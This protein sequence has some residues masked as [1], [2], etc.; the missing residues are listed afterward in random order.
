MSARRCKHDPAFKAKVALA[1]LREDATPASVGLGH[2]CDNDEERHVTPPDLTRAR[3]R[4]LVTAAEDAASVALPLETAGP[5]PDTLRSRDVFRLLR[6]V[7]PFVRPYKRHLLYLIIAMLP[8]LVL[9]LAGLILIQIFFDVI[10]HGHSMTRYEAIMLNLPVTA[11]RELVL[12]RACIAASVLLVA[13]IPVFALTFGYAV[14][15]LQRISN[16][17]RVSLYSRL[18][19]LSLRF[20]SEAKIGDAI[21]RMFQDSAAV[22]QVLDGLVIQ[23]I[24]LLPIAT[25]TLVFLLVM[26]YPMALIAFAIIPLNL[27]LAWSFASPMRRQFLRARLT[28][29]IATTRMEET[30]TAIRAVKAFGGEEAE[31]LTYARENWES[32]VAARRA[33][34]LFAA[35]LVLTNS[36]RGL[37]YAGALYFGAREVLAGGRT[38][39]MH[40]GFS[41][42]LF[43]ASLSAFSAMSGR[44]RGLVD[45]WGSLQDVAVALERVFEML[46]KRPDSDL[47]NGQIIASAP[48]R[49]LAF[50]DVGFSYGGPPVFSNIGFEARVGELTAI[51][52]AS[53]CGK[54]TLIALALRFFDPSSGRILL[55]GRDVRDFDLPTYRALLGT[56]LQENPLFTATLRDNLTYGRPDATS[57]E[58]E[59]AVTLADLS[60]FVRALPAGLDTMLGE[61]G[62]RL[63]AGQAQRIGLAR[64]FLR[65]API[66]L[67][68]EPTSALDPATEDRVISQVRAW[69]N[70]QPQQRLVL[71]ATHRESTAAHADRTYRITA[72][73]IVR[74]DEPT[75]KPLPARTEHNG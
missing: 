26:S 9:G 10:G 49:S 24:R 22:W 17:F 2:C 31:K 29:A 44:T 47:I 39:L 13:G 57:D 60:E 32:F 65:D 7:W 71:I 28:S 23:P 18:Q 68:D 48:H 37:A 11:G 52:G 40:A 3:A 50:E 56:G 58:V 20:H 46:N 64:A 74:A 8:G 53:G 19:E 61:K 51:T 45:R 16:L 54:S 69:V 33:R 70:E 67:L 38:A 59:R 42:G 1:A 5:G 43:Q 62:A 25:G 41:L 12:W 55:D 4:P 73:C 72:G 14:W 27:L 66:L 21:F 63:S 35:Y 75:F 30:L 36:V 34:L 6:R 15:L